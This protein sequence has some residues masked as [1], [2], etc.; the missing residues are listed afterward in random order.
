MVT[1]RTV[2]LEKKIQELK[3]SEEKFQKAF[4]SSAAGITIARISD[5]NSLM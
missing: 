3:E 1:E 4:E 5:V 2:E